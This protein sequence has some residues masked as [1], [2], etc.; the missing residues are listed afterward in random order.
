MLLSPS[1]FRHIT[2]APVLQDTVVMHLGDFRSNAKDAPSTAQPLYAAVRNALISRLVA[3]PPPTSELQVR[4]YMRV[5]RQAARM[6]GT[7]RESQGYACLTARFTASAKKG[8]VS[9]YHRCL[10]PPAGFIWHPRCPCW[11]GHPCPCH[12]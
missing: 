8:D 2:L 9:L 11:H 10:S 6:S 7:V 1:T 3:L 4:T 5:S 12:C